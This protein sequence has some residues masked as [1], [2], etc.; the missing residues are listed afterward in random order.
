MLLLHSRAGAP[1]VGHGML[2]RRAR[3]LLLRHTLALIFI[4]VAAVAAQRR[5]RQLNNPRHPRQQLAVVAGDQSP[6]L[7][8]FQLVIE[9]LPPLAVQM[10]GRLI[11]QQIIGARDEGAAQQSLHPLAAAE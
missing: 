1:S 6:A 3:G 7:P 5:R 8:A 2:Q 10:V 9:P 11:Q 4:I